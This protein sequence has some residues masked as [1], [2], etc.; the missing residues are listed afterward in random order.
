MTTRDDLCRRSMRTTWLGVALLCLALLFDATPAWAQEPTS[1]QAPAIRGMRSEVQL[2]GFIPWSVVGSATAGGV[3]VDFDVDAGDV[4]D[5][6]ELGRAVRAEVWR[7]PLAF[8]VDALY[9]EF[10]QEGELRMTQIPIDVEVQ[11]LTAD[12][13]LG[14]VPLRDAITQLELHAGVRAEFSDVS[15]MIGD[16]ERSAG[17]DRA[18]F[19]GEAEVPFRVTESWHMRARGTL[20]VP[21]SVSFTFLGIAEYHIG[22]FAIGFGY[23]YDSFESDGRRVAFDARAHNAYLS[24]G[25]DFGQQL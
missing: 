24:L 13:M 16:A 11:R 17:R 1:E 7:G 22:R 14:W 6:L 20:A 18:R 4:L 10:G 8:I 15:I 9:L 21:G 23:R 19:V 12:I 2:Y 5:V 3:S 25:M